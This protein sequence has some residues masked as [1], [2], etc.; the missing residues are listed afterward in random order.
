MRVPPLREAR[1]PEIVQAVQELI[2][3]GTNA[4]GICTLTAN[5][6]ST[7]VNNANC[8]T[9]SAVL[10]TAMTANAAG[11]TGVYVTPGDRSFVITHNNTAAT[12]KRFSYLVLNVDN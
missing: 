10:L 12:D 7:T 8:S 6:T 4:G 11:S 1:L 9:R 2:R 3:G 5:A